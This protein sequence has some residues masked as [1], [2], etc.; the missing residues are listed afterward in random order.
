MRRRFSINDAGELV[1][2]DGYVLGRVTSLTLEM[3]PDVEL[4]EGGLQGVKPSAQQQRMETSEAGGGGVGEESKTTPE[5]DPVDAVWTTY[6]ETMRPRKKDLDA[7]GRRVIRDALKVATVVECQRAILGCS[8]SDWHM[9]RDPRTNGKSYRQ[10]S[11]I[12]KG[13][14]G[15]RTTREQIDLFL[16][17]ADRSGLTTGRVPSADTAKVA[18][19]KRDVLTAWEF[20]GDEHSVAQAAE[21]ERWLAEHGVSTER[22]DD[23]RPRFRWEDQA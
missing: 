19:A 15:G 2:R 5:P 1:D 21:S 14:R 12:L 11:Q 10:L 18:A 9:G 20:P 6:V 4:P 23:G 8:K 22:D 13:K 17:I 3:R 7:G 16:E